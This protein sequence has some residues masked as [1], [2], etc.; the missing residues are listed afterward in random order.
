MGRSAADSSALIPE[1][2]EKKGEPYGAECLSISV[3]DRKEQIKPEWKLSPG[4]RCE[5]KE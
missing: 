5:T 4:R 1:N 3:L 2:C